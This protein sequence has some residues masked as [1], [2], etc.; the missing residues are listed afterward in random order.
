[1]QLDLDVV[2]GESVLYSERVR[3]GPHQDASVRGYVRAVDAG[4]DPS[5]AARSFWA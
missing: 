3:R 1:L 4:R 2:L 5:L